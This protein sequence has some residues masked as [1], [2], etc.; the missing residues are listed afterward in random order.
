MAYQPID[1]FRNPTPEREERMPLDNELQP[2]PMLDERGP[3]ATKVMMFAVAAAALL[4][5]LFYG[6][7]GSSVNQAGTE[8][9]P[10]TAQTRPATPSAPP[11]TRDVTPRA[12]TEPGTTTGAAPARPLPATPQTDNP[13]A[14]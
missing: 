13:G 12:N 4:G 7:N 2:D 10:R 6:L 1:P 9:A 8:P 3:S 14:K 11:G 5:A